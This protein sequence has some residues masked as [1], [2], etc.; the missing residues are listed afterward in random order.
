MRTRAIEN[1]VFILTANRTGIERGIKFTGKSQIVSPTGDLILRFGCRERGIKIVEIEPS[2]AL[3]K[4]ITDYNHIFSDRR[5][6]F[7]Q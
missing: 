3:D 2:D 5:P 1:R 7:Y 6:E 4:N